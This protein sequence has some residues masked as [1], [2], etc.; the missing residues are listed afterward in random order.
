M[1]LRW[2][3][4]YFKKHK[5]LPYLLI[6]LIPALAWFGHQGYRYYEGR[7]VLFALRNIHTAGEWYRY[8]ADH[9]IKEAQYNLGLLYRRGFTVPKDDKEAARWMR[10][11]SD[12]D[13]ALAQ[14][15][16]GTYYEAG[17]G[18][19]KN[20]AEAAKLYQRA[21]NQGL[22]TA[23]NHLAGLLLSGDGVKEDKST[24]LKWFEKAA[25]EGFIPAQLNLA[26][27]YERGNG[28]PSDPV[29]AYAW[30][31]VADTGTDQTAYQTPINQMAARLMNAM[32]EPTRLK[33][34]GMAKLYVDQYGSKTREQFMNV[35]KQ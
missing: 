28:V 14:N 4:H 3:H 18:V 25:G 32:D 31:A 11:A 8:G 33:A 26:T 17:I 10:K 2:P 9:E 27:A 22:P 23:M 12:H 6:I 21:A 13:L 16:L 5:R 29:R 35:L 7:Q 19:P 34:R 20:T 30:I 15:E 1:A 24:A